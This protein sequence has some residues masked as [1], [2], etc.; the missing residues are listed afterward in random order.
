[1]QN[2]HCK[3][4]WMEGKSH[5]QKERIAD[6]PDG[7][8]GQHALVQLVH[9]LEISGSVRLDDRNPVK[10]KKRQPGDEK[11]DQKQE[12]GQSELPMVSF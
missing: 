6:G 8:M 4:G 7:E 11:G 5:F 1:M 9:D 12:P 2:N 10:E 3:I